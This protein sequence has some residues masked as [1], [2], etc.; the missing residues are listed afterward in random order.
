M[1]DPFLKSKQQFVIKTIN[2]IMRSY[3]NIKYNIKFR[4]GKKNTPGTLLTD[5]ITKEHTFVFSNY[6]LKALLT[7]E[8][9]NLIKHECAHAISGEQ[10]TKQFKTISKKLHLPERWQHRKIKNIAIYNSMI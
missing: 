8:L 7:Y 2:N 4:E 5:T 1:I 9:T 6:Y 10:H 3:P